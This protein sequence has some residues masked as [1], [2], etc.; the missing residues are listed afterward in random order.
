MLTTD[1]YV[2]SPEAQ[3]QNTKKRCLRARL[4]QPR[5][6]CP[7]VFHI[8]TSVWTTTPDDTLSD[9]K[10]SGHAMLVVGY[11]DNIA[12][13]AFRVLNS[14]GTDW[15]DHG[16]IWIKYKDFTQWCVLGVQAFPDM[17][18]PAPPGVKRGARTRTKARTET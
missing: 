14:W 4:Y 6:I 12:G 5:S 17:Q 2:V 8:K 13:G 1:Q 10:H 11:D 3:I 9:W 18:T 15:A 7:K 16:F